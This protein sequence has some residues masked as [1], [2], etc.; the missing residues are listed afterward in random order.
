MVQT[1]E[2]RTMLDGSN[3]APQVD[4]LYLV[5][6]TGLWG[7]DITSNPRI[8]G[9]FYD[10][11]SSGGTYV[12]ELDVTGDSQADQSLTVSPYGN[13]E[14]NP[15]SLLTI[16]QSVVAR[17]R[18]SETLDTGEGS[19]TTAGNWNTLSFLYSAATDAGEAP[20][21]DYLYLANDTG[22]WGDSITSD[23]RITGTLYDTDQTG[24][25]YVAELD[26]NGDNVPEQTLTVTAGSQFTFSPASLLTPDHVVNAR[27]RGREIL[28]SSLGTSNIAGSWAPITFTYSAQSDAGEAP[29]IDYLY[30]ANDT[31][32]WGDAVTSDAQITGS[33]YD[34]DSTGGTYAAELDLTGDGV[35]ELTTSSIAGGQF[36]FSPASFLTPGQ[37]VTA[38][39]RGRETLT[40]G[41][42]TSTVY[43]AWATLTFTYSAIGDAGQAPQ[44]DYL[45]L[46][47]DTGEY[48]DAITTDARIT[49]TL[50]DPDSTG[51]VYTAE[52]DINDDNVIDQ[53]VT[54]GGSGQFEFNPALLLTTGQQV[55]AR[56]RGRETLTNSVG[57]SSLT[58]S[59]STLQF[60]YQG[61]G[62]GPTNPPPTNIL[63]L[64]FT[65]DVPSGS[66][67]SGR[68]G[69]Q[70]GTIN[71]AARA[72]TKV[73][74]ETTVEDDT[75]TYTAIF[76]RV[77]WGG[78]AADWTFTRITTAGV[79]TDE[80]WTGWASPGFFWD[81]LLPP[82]LTTFTSDEGGGV[83]SGNSFAHLYMVNDTTAV[84]IEPAQDMTAGPDAY[85]AVID[86][87][88]GT[89]S[90]GQ[91]DYDRSG[92]SYSV[93]TYVVQG[94]HTY[95]DM[96]EYG[97]T[98]QA[99]G[100][101][102]WSASGPF[103]YGET[104]TDEIA[105]TVVPQ[106]LT[107][108]LLSPQPV[109]G[110]SFTEAV[111]TFTDSGSTVSASSYQAKI[112]WGDSGWSNGTIVA[113]GQGGYR[114]LGTHTYY[115]TGSKALEVRILRTNGAE[116]L[117]T[118]TVA[119]AAAA[120]LTLTA[121]VTSDSVHLGRFA[122]Y[123]GES[124]NGFAARALIR[125]S[126]QTQ[127]SGTTST[128][129]AVYRYAQLGP[130]APTWTYERI[131][132]NGIVTS[133][134]WTGLAIPRW[135]G[136]PEWMPPQLTVFERGSTGV[137][138]SGA[139]EAHLQIVN[140]GL[141]VLFEPTGPQWTNPSDYVA[142]VDWGDGTTSFAQ[143]AYDTGLPDLSLMTFG[144]RG[145]HT[146]TTPGQYAI[147]VQT[148][149]PQI[150]S[151]DGSANHGENWTG[152]VSA[153]VVPQSLTAVLE[154]P[155]PVMGQ[156]FSG[157]VATFTDSGLAV[158]AS[159]YNA[160]ITWGDGG[161]SAG[162]IISDG[163]GG[164]RVH[165]THTYNTAGN[166]PLH[167]Q[168][169]R[170]Q[171]ATLTI[172]GSLTVLS[173][174]PLHAVK[175]NP[176]TNVTVS[177][178]P[179]DAIQWGNTTSM[180]ES[181]RW[182]SE[183]G[184][185]WIRFQTSSGIQA[186]YQWSV[187]GNWMGI[188]I[189][190]WD[191]VAQDYWSAGLSDADG[192]GVFV[193]YDGSVAAKIDHIN[194]LMPAH[195][196]WVR[197]GSPLDQSPDVLTAIIDWGDGTTS[198][199]T[200]TGSS[201]ANG[202]VAVSASH[203]YLQSG[204]YNVTTAINGPSG[205]LWSETL[206]ARTID[207]S[208]EPIAVDSGSPTDEIVLGS[209]EFLAEIDFT[210]APTFQ[211]SSID[212]SPTSQTETYAS[213][214]GQTVFVRASTLDA[215]NHWT[216]VIVETSP[217]GQRTYTIQGAEPDL[218]GT[219]DGR[220]W[221]QCDGGTLKR[222]DAEESAVTASDYSVTIDWGDGTSS[223]GHIVV[224]GDYV[225]GGYNL[226]N[227]V[228]T[229]NYSPGNFV[230]SATATG[231]NFR[232]SSGTPQSGQFVVQ[233]PIVSSPAS[234]T[235]GG[236]NTPASA[237]VFNRQFFSIP[238]NL[239]LTDPT[240]PALGALI[241][242][243]SATMPQGRTALYGTN[244]RGIT[245][246]SQPELF[247]SS[248]PQNLPVFVFS[249]GNVRINT[250]TYNWNGETVISYEAWRFISHMLVSPNTMY[251]TAYDSAVYTNDH[252][253][254]PYFHTAH[255]RD[256]SNTAPLE[257]AIEDLNEAPVA[258]DLYRE[259][260]TGQT[261]YWPMQ[262][263]ATQ[264]EAVGTF[265]GRV[266]DGLSPG[267]I[268][269]GATDPDY[270]SA[271]FGPQSLQFT[272]DGPIPG[273]RLSPSGGL[274]VDGPLLP[275]LYKVGVTATDGGGL[276]APSNPVWLKVDPVNVAIEVPEAISADDASASVAM[277]VDSE[278]DGLDGTSVT[279]TLKKAGTLAV[280][281]TM[282]AT[283]QDGIA[284]VQ[285][286]GLSTV[287]LTYYIVEVS[288]LG[289]THKSDVFKVVAGRPD[290]VE[291]VAAP[292]QSN[293][294]AD[295]TSRSKVTAT[296]YDQFGNVA[297]DETGVSWS[298]LGDQGAIGGPVGS[299]NAF[300]SELSASYSK[301]YLGSASTFVRAPA[302]PESQVV[303]A[304]AG[305]ASAA[306]TLAVAPVAGALGGP[307]SL[308]I[309]GESGAV[310]LSTNAADGTPVYW[311][312]TNGNGDSRNVATYV[313]AGESSIDVSPT[314][315][316][317]RVGDCVVL[318]TV[319]SL[320]LAHE[321]RFDPA[322]QSFYAEFDRFVIGG[323]TTTD[324][325]FNVAPMISSFAHVPPPS[326][327]VMSI[328]ANRNHNMPYYAS[329]TATIH[330]A[331]SGFVQVSVDAGSFA[332]VYDPQSQMSGQSLIIP[333]DADGVAQIVV[334]SLG[335]LQ[336]WNGGMTVAT[337]DIG[338]TFA[339]TTG[340]FVAPA[341]GAK[342]AVTTIKA[343]PTGWGARVADG[344]YGFIGGDPTGVAGIAGNVA[345][346]MLIIGDVG[347]VIKN[348]WRWVG[349]TV[350]LTTVS[351][352][353]LETAL[354][355]IGIL[356][357]LAVGAGEVA[358]APVS[359]V[360]AIVAAVGKTKFSDVLVI[361]LNRALSNASDL[362]KFGSF[363][364]GMI[365]SDNRF[366]LSKVVFQSEDVMEAGVRVSDEL[367]DGFWSMLEKNV[368]EDPTPAIRAT[369]A[370]IEGAT[371]ATKAIDQMLTDVPGLAA[372][373]K[374][375]SP[376]DLT[377]ALAPIARILNQGGADATRLVS[378]IKK[379]FANGLLKNGS[380][381]KKLFEQMDKICEAQGFADL[382]KSMDN[383][384]VNTLGGR[385]YELTAAVKIA[386]DNAAAVGAGAR[387]M[388]LSV[389][390]HN[391]VGKT[392]IDIAIGTV[393]YQ[394]KWSI[395]AMN[396]SAPK[397]E[398]WLAKARA[399]GGTDFYLVFPGTFSD[400]SGPLQ[401]LISTST[402]IATEQVARVF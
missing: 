292:I 197:I 188:D 327:A 14:F 338:V 256:F 331:P 124:N 88:D 304:T 146:Y 18:V 296:V 98:V 153:T 348:S 72:L 210:D 161:I 160:T 199:G 401:Q 206:P 152:L 79:V 9:S 212:T 82:A 279:F 86:W 367:G 108:T 27:V 216:T 10:P 314:G 3:E 368:I 7:D 306:I 129:T 147:T 242:T 55:T 85:V 119:A 355:G 16:G 132:T 211:Q 2:T 60:T 371:A 382:I 370:G 83:W 214:D 319:G 326:A 42:G 170:R 353:Y 285:F 59:W 265:V 77:G 115:D 52:L 167:V 162:T 104:W 239:S 200:L 383:V 335:Q 109:L 300:G 298:M 51:G 280:V 37:T 302:L 100:P 198:P 372:H 283:V 125:D 192:D 144:V 336:P 261:Y 402:D 91:V 215:T 176:L 139:S 291:L 205:V 390:V 323:D 54:V 137:F 190:G 362:T 379:G 43:G 71:K 58:G 282:T 114:V 222:V 284:A 93:P 388:K 400:L 203:T 127:V 258:P 20:Q 229:H 275:G 32:T 269:G 321:L 35:A 243:V 180:T 15:A 61:E 344:A 171:G 80:H 227:I 287:A 101:E 241:G 183:D 195:L 297:Q 394:C 232:S 356:T 112:V 378:V 322:D 339:E 365:S 307:D 30:L 70:S 392:D 44:A 74:E 97:I 236:G 375:L 81:T 49:G 64:R 252:D 358:D 181:Q 36:T 274:F 67:V 182:S 117:A 318:A 349:T 84:L 76:H 173:V 204:H 346:G 1:L 169:H 69:V 276:S 179:Y 230:A 397:I 66:I 23:P 309:D 107:A 251:V 140:D 398:K 4:Y 12:V 359:G 177:R 95:A 8:T 301:T 138:R 46:V 249:N 26:L 330:G 354:S 150:L 337:L 286:T 149:G 220:W 13:F 21:M 369:Q 187:S 366:A 145:E 189:F 175:N 193:A 209:F 324:G 63:G 121:E 315:K 340:P 380:D 395:D 202:N 118:G 168:I 53:S 393:H 158:A 165:G 396:A 345:G 38:R 347:S 294:V 244:D 316:W 328:L 87:G 217:E 351:P 164:F 122:V 17:V 224:E 123:E 266:R 263:F 31:G 299:T 194:S 221:I 163:A 235:S 5:Q 273:I 213:S 257:I 157:A 96:G 363:V 240:N 41:V 75:T 341:P 141:A 156:A 278:L 135:W 34:S 130:N 29:Q 92:Q 99:F 131:T 268:Y 50:Y 40:T 143:I 254:D 305:T 151:L 308:V 73:S 120:P 387:N 207:A 102:F 78:S 255:S 116:V 201:F 94:E 377:A 172:N 159:E 48:G 142:V 186:T 28:T 376:A 385:L 381:F 113:D 184:S 57:T 313:S 155:Q 234:N 350:G 325:V 233:S 332:E 253:N 45:Y 320:T 357:E 133:E 272:L 250:S 237:I 374:A 154:D 310:D 111:A 136:M 361:L 126:E 11:D 174:P 19:V 248:M 303:V 47:N 264:G 185:L 260:Y 128:Y 33:L 68:F 290:R 89:T 342:V 312:I 289:A 360:R 110:E 245:D 259:P 22:T 288:Y 391:V 105:A 364:K 317:A 373:L 6:D 218:W 277:E 281:S 39:V 247:L 333:L 134:T 295:S 228:G 90:L 334:R 166:Q 178:M 225:A 329:A 352:N 231:P 191:P 103:N 24:G 399:E 65:E 106:T 271:A 223:V 208:G 267:G 343:V 262:V 293:Y 62:G 384:S 148:F 246:E 25:A 226:A 56:V 270:Y 219:A 386:S 238:E 311:L 196:S 389:P